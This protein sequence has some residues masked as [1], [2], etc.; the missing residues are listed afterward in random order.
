VSAGPS[1][2]S[3]ERELVVLAGPGPATDIAVH[4]L[5][6]AFGEV[7]VVME[8]PQSRRAL[9]WRRAK[10]IGA[11]KAFGQVLFSAA[12]SPVLG[13]AARGRIA[14]IVEA[15]GFD[16]SPITPAVTVPSVNDETARRALRTAR[17]AVVVV[18]GT[19]IISRAT[20]GSTDA[21]FVNMHAGITPRYRGVH[22]GYWALAEGC[23][24]LVGTT[25]HR[26]DAGVDTGEVLAQATFAVTGDDSFATYP[27]L[28]LA[29]GL[30]LLIDVVGDLLDGR[31]VEPRASIS[32]PESRLYYHPTAWGY[33]ST[34]WR[35]SVA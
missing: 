10:R 3:P 31:P 34:R 21:P 13:Y 4:R 6:A 28:H 19:R 5:E 12:V 15:E 7:T 30:P 24:D 22:G 29:A 25:I 2:T 23:P 1:G 9:A 32:G 8:E 20:L 11:G 16:L 14:S 18:S 17:P 27:Y 33:L 35:R 26:I